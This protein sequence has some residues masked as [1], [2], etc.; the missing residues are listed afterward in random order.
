MQV[1]DRYYLAAQVIHRITS[2]NVCYTKLLRVVGGHAAAVGLRREQP[3]RRVER[4]ARV[5]VG[6]DAP[7]RGAE[8]VVDAA[9]DGLGADVRRVR[10]GD[11]PG[12]LTDEAGGAVRIEVAET[13]GGRERDGRRVGA[14]RGRRDGRSG[15]ANRP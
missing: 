7:R 4:G 15:E 13:A 10:Y 8:R 9:R 5:E 11:G 14:V 3:P 6:D 12:R 1:D 2:Y